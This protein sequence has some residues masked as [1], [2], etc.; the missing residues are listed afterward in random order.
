MCQN[1]LAISRFELF[2]E[3]MQ[4]TNGIRDAAFLIVLRI[5]MFKIVNHGIE[6]MGLADNL[7]WV[8][9]VLDMYNMHMQMIWKSTSADELFFEKVTIKNCKGYTKCG[10]IVEE[11][12]KLVG[13]NV[14]KVFWH[15][16]Q[17]F[18]SDVM[19]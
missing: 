13:G 2:I 3:W 19:Q 14:R 8:R 18:V 1:L 7:S 11:K 16:P 9:G 5:E 12:S 4:N 15:N 10:L 17:D 6:Q